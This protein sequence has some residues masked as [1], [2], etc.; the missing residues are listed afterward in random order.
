MQDIFNEK[1]LSRL[2]KNTYELMKLII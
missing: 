2:K 1:V